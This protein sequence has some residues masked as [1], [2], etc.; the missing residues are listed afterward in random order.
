MTG[1]PAHRQGMT[2]RVTTE[3]HGRAA[4]LVGVKAAHTLIWLSI[5]ACVGYLIWSGWTRRTD[6]R[7]GI[8]GT[9][10]ATE[11]L[12]F[13]GSGFRCPLTAVAA[14]LG[15]GRGSVTDIFLP[16]WFARWLP[17]LHVPLLLLVAWW[18]GRNALRRPGQAR[19]RRWRHPSVTGLPTAGIPGPSGTAA[20]AAQQRRLGP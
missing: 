9:I 20:E 7:A 1:R 4:L 14:S 16:A 18:H 17:A 8:A 12:V 6:R 10:V 15:D 5:E 13:A 19:S 2:P 11:C 3:L